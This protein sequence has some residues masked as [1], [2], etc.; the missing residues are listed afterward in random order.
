VEDQNKQINNKDETIKYL[1]EE[2]SIKEN[3]IME[4]NKDVK[5]LM[6]DRAKMK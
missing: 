6:D 1:E 4:L 3:E 2:I 5:H